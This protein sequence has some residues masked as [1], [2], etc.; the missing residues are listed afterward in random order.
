MLR[1]V[2]PTAIS[3]PISTTNVGGAVA[4]IDVCISIKII[5]IV[6]RNVVISAPA[7]TPT[8]AAAP[9]RS[10]RNSN[11]KGNGH[12]GCVI[13]GRGVSN[14]WIWIRGRPVNDCRVITRHVDDLRAGLFDDDYLF[15]FHNLGLYLLLF[16]AL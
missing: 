5:I 6:N 14:G 8:P 9:R 12:P 11:P 1:I 2:F 3:A 16:V 13:A 15:R 4:S 7:R 10:H